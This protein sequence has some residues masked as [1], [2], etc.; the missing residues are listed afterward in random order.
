MNP[1]KIGNTVVLCEERKQESKHEGQHPSFI[2]PRPPVQ[3]YPDVPKIYVEEKQLG[4]GMSTFWCPLCRKD[5]GLNILSHL[6]G[7]LYAQKAV[8]EYQVKCLEVDAINIARYNKWVKN[9]LELFKIQGLSQHAQPSSAENTSASASAPGEG[10]ADS[11]TSPSS[12]TSPP[13]GV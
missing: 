11:Q 7:C 4:P 6:S 13:G 12:E 3:Q 9:S 5:A 1:V 10:P 8:Q 2:L